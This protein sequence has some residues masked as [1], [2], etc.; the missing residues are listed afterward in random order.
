MRMFLCGEWQD[1][2]QQIPVTNPYRGT[3][4]DTVPKA[5]AADVDKAL[6]TLTNGA[7][8]MKQMS[9]YDRS[10]ILRRR[11]NAGRGCRFYLSIWDGAGRRRIGTR[12][13]S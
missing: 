9:A 12:P 13:V 10:Q 7:A 1:R 6:A 3:V 5:A 2:P 11:P 8:V 4:I